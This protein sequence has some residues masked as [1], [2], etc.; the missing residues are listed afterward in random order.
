M[1][2]LNREIFQLFKIVLAEDR[3]QFIPGE[4][5]RGAVQGTPASKPVD[6]TLAVRL[7]WYTSGKGTRDFTT[8]DERRYKLSGVAKCDFQFEFTAPRRPLSFSGQLIG[9]QWAIEAVCLPSKRSTRVDIV[10]AHRPDQIRLESVA[11][12]MKASG[13]HKPWLTME[14]R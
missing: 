9:L 11:E 12:Q 1:L 8:V 10:L 4:M 6:E 14:G 7:I 13:I 3:L 5:I 2:Q